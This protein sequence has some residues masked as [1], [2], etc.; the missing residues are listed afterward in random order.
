MGPSLLPAHVEGP[1]LLLTY[2]IS[3]LAVLPGQGIPKE[4]R[5]WGWRS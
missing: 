5:P 3:I 1:I 2:A 4:A